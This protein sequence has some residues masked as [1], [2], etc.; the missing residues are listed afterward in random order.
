MKR[1]FG[2]S[3]LLLLAITSSS[4]RALAD[5]KA[6]A[7]AVFHVGVERYK[8]K[9]FDAACTSFLSAYSLDPQPRY[10]WNLALS[11]V[12]CQHPL[13]ALAHFRRYLALP[14]ATEDDRRKARKPMAE[15]RAM[16]AH[17]ELDLPA[18]ASVRVDG[19]DATVV[20][21]TIDMMPGRH[22][23]VASAG[24]ATASV[25]IEGAAGQVLHPD[26]RFEA[27]TPSAPPAS[28][29]SAPPVAPMPEPDAPSTASTATWWT[30]PRYLGLGVGGLAV[31]GLITGAAFRVAYS[32]SQTDAATLRSS[33]PSGACTSSSPPSSCGDL[34]D[35]INAGSQNVTLSTVSFVVGGVAAAA[36]AGLLLFGGGGS[37]ARSGALEWSPVI[38]VGSAGIA[39]RF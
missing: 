18:D 6:D 3:A 7:A 9:D 37:S 28:S 39:G 2:F 5:E 34:Q 35:K 20:D 36:S 24:Q 15:A 23:I 1:S 8:L 17:V 31:V 33:I 19:Q 30:M 4:A 14:S 22:T 25:V 38:G 26:L 13:E 29:P 16:T 21:R 10:L 11:E 32:N 27:P 12:H